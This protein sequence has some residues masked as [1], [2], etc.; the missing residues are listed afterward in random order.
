MSESERPGAAHQDAAL[1]GPREVLAETWRA[2][3]ER[4]LDRLASLF[5]EDVVYDSTEVS[6]SII[7]GR[8]RLREYFD[9]VISL[10]DVIFDVE[11]LV[12][13]DDQVVSVIGVRG[14][15]DQSGAPILGR[16]GQVATVSDGLVTHVR[17]YVDPREALA[18]TGIGS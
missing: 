8:S 5:A 16:L 7:N 17:L 18:R 11:T 14:R 13:V 2:W 12:E 4:D 10:S 9:E 15:G 1:L 6:D 3:N